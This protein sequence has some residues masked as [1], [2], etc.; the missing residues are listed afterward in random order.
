MNTKR[1]IAPNFCSQTI[2]SDSDTNIDIILN[3]AHRRGTVHVV[4]ATADTADDSLA[5]LKGAFGGRIISRDL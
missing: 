5:A 3:A 2:N 4:S 1:I